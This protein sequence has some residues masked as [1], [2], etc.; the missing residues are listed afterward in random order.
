MAKKTIF[1]YK[2]WGLLFSICIIFSI[3]Q[4]GAKGFLKTDGT[5]IVNDN[6]E[7]LCVG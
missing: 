1:K 6:G 2:K 5:K 3:S 7:I 4:I